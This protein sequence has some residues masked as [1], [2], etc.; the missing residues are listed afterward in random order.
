MVEQP[1]DLHTVIRQGTYRSVTSAIYL[2]HESYLSIIPP[3]ENYSPTN[4]SA[5]LRDSRFYLQKPYF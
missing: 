3:L 4:P 5:R 2:P 1:L